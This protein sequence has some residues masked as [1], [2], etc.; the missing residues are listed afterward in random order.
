VVVAYLTL[1]GLSVGFRFAELRKSKPL[2]AGRLFVSLDGSVW[3]SRYFRE[4]YAWPVLEEMRYVA[5]EPSL[6]L[7]GTAKGTRIWDKVYSI[8]S[9]RRA[10][11]SWVNRGAWHNEPKPRGTRQATKTEVYEHGR[12]KLQGGAIDARYNQW[13]LVER[14]ALTMLCM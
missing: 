6:Q 14:L 8:H 5:K 12:W 2:E 11:R 9:W 13:G 1:S 4:Q 3:T 10:G 7:F